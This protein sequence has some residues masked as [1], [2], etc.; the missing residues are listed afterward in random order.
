M[1]EVLEMTMLSPSNVVHLS[2]EEIL[3]ALRCVETVGGGSAK[4]IGIGVRV[5]RT[6]A[7]TGSHPLLRAEGLINE[8]THFTLNTGGLL[9]MTHH[10]GPFFHR[11][12]LRGH[13]Q[14]IPDPSAADGYHS[15]MDAPTDPDVSLV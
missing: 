8:A 15:V 1:W 2:E 10:G 14:Y 6:I 7:G 9:W 11:Q 4:N 5:L 3:Y 13:L 12:A